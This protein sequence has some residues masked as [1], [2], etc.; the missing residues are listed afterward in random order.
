MTRGKPKL[1]TVLF[2]VIAAMTIGIILFIITKKDGALKIIEERHEREKIG[3]QSADTGGEKGR[4]TEED[5]YRIYQS[6]YV[7]IKFNKPEHIDTP[8]EE[9]EGKK[10]FQ[11]PSPQSEAPPDAMM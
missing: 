5:G 9:E 3:T 4:I 11:L 1:K 8:P 7:K 2:I 10:E 6:K